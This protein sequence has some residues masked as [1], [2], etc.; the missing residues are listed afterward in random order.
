LK[1]P[2]SRMFGR[3]ARPGLIIIGQQKN[4]IEQ[5]ASFARHIHASQHLEK[6][7]IV[8]TR[9]AK[10]DTLDLLKAEKAEHGI[11]HCFTEDY[12]TAK[13]ALD[14]GFYISLSGIV[15]FK[16]ATELQAVAKKL[17]KDRI[18]IE[19]DSPYLAPVPKRGKSNE[20]AFVPYVAD[21]LA[22]HYDMPVDEFAHLTHQNF[23]ALL[24][25]YA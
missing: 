21:F 12:D 4:S 1:W 5:K 16:N 8:H 24:H 6:P 17:P 15:T 9:E 7:I 20:P 18:L 11:I 2:I 14:L 10:H 13:K 19:T 23:D 3:L 22:K 25:Q